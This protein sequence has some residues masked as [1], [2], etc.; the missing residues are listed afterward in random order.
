MVSIMMVI[1]TSAKLTGVTKEE[2]FQ[3]RRNC[4]WP[5]V[6]IMVYLNWSN[7]DFKLFRAWDWGDDD[8][9]DDDDDVDD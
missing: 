9:D 6:E 1:I 3:K 4:K 5:I 8:D 2:R 7:F